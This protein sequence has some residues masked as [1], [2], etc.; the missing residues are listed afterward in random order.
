VDI[1]AYIT[2]GKLELYL[3][4]ELSELERAEVIAIAAKF[5]EVQK[6]PGDLEEA[7]F[8]IDELTGKIPSAA[9]KTKI[10]IR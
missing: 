9:I 3:L 5:P 10:S 6:E 2:S 4:G 8:A 7:M 1:Q